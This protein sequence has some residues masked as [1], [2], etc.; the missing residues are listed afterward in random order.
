MKFNSGFKQGFYDGRDH[1]FTTRNVSEYLSKVVIPHDIPVID[2]GNVVPCCV[3][4]SVTTCLEVMDKQPNTSLSFMYNYYWARTSPN[5]LGKLD[6]RQGL[7]AAAEYGIC[8]ANLHHVPLNKDGAMVRPSQI[9]I[10]DGNK[11]KIAFNPVISSWE[12]QHFNNTN[13]VNSWKNAIQ[14]GMP[15]IMGFFITEAYENI[16]FAQNIHSKPIGL[17]T[18][19]HAVTV[20]GYDDMHENNMPELGAFYIRDSRGNGFADQGYWWLPYSLV[21]THLVVDSW[22]VLRLS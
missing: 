3:S 8:A 9:A 7:D 5:N 15:I 19:G 2:Q 21:D 22:T 1:L 12:Y 13:R 20:M 17:S 14:S 16:P 18:D 10:N 6:I 4:I 11:R